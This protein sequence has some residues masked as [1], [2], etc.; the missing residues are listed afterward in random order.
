VLLVLFERKVIT[1]AF[2]LEAHAGPL[3]PLL[4]ADVNFSLKLSNNRT[5]TVQMHNTDVMP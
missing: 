1:A 3:R 5:T 2:S 4:P